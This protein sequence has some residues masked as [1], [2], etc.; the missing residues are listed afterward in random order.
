MRSV[1]AVA[2]LAVAATGSSSDTPPQKPLAEAIRDALAAAPVDGVSARVTFTNKLFPSGALLG[3]AAPVAMAGGS[4]RLWM[5]GDG[6]GRIELQSD[7]GD[8]QILWTRTDVTVYDA[9]S[10]T[11]YHALLPVSQPGSAAPDTPP[12]LARITD[13]LNELGAHATVTGA[14]PTDVAG[15]AAYSTS[16]SPKHDGGL[17]GSV[18]M[19]WDAVRGVPLRIAVYTQGAAAPVLA[20]TVTQI[21]YGPVDSAAVDVTAPSNAKVVEVGQLTPGGGKQGA[22]VSGLTNVRAAAGFDVA[23][24]DTLVGLPRRDVRL[25]G[26]AESHTVVVT[27]G[28]GLGAIVVAER[29]ATAGSGPGGILGS[30]PTVSLDGVSAHELATQLGTVIQWE[31]NGVTTTLAGSVPTAAAEAAARELR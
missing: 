16:V 27:F 20:L 5:T 23:A 14:Q 15:T 4:G 30:L 9:A 8:A 24:P 25:V 10:N 2:V 13:L 6:R 31:R 1:A 3:N 19:A 18:E 11:A 7:A 28:Q 22:V 26:D 17:L 29:K 12:S 21:A